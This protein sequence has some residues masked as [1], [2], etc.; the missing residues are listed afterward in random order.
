M[1]HSKKYI[2]VLKKLAESMKPGR[3]DMKALLPVHQDYS[4]DARNIYKAK[5][6]MRMET[7][8]LSHRASIWTNLQRLD[9]K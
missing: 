7:V 6:A 3:C 9:C 2:L 1:A 8:L 5:N 4:N